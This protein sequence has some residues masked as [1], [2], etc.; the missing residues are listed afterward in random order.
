MKNV[1]QEAINAQGDV[2]GRDINKTFNLNLTEKRSKYLCSLMEKFK[3]ERDD[4][5]QIST[6]IDELTHYK[7][8]IISENIIGLENKLRKGNREDLIDD[9]L[10]T[11]EK[12]TK[13]LL[14]Y[15]AFESAQGIYAYLLAHVYYNF[16]MHILPL[17][18]EKKYDNSEINIFID[19]KV[20]EP[21]Y[22]ELDENV[23]NI[24]KDEIN[25]MLYFLTGNCHIKWM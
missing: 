12:F 8:P 14:K 25:G 2:A 24:F 3:K 22:S 21:L 19:E 7:T 15:E 6:I 13:K 18:I 5:I 11:K 20:I 9:A 1:K 10:I 17:I 16:K 4:N 23:L